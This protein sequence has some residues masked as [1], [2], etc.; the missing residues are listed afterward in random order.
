MLGF[1]IKFEGG[2]NEDSIVDGLVTKSS[3]EEEVGLSKPNPSILTL[4]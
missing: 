2:Y 3:Y 1:T 4:N